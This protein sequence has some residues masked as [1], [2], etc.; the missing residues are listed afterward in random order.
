MAENTQSAACSQQEYQAARQAGLL[1]VTTADERAIHAFAEAIRA[2][3]T[4]GIPFAD[5]E[6]P[7]ILEWGAVSLPVGHPSRITATKLCQTLWDAMADGA[8]CGFD[9][10]V[11]PLALQPSPKEQSC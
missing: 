11:Y 2:Q 3:A 10:R 5:G 8:L 4:A 1:V 7:C 9:W 6:N